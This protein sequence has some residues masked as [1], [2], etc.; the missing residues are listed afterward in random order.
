M[1]EYMP[2]DKN[3]NVESVGIPDDD[4]DETH[5]EIS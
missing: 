2:L 3:A 1:A 5:I 4:D